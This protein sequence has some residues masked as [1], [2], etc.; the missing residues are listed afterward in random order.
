MNQDEKAIKKFGKIRNL[1]YDYVRAKAVLEQHSLIEY[2]SWDGKKVTLVLRTKDIPDLKPIMA[3]C[4]TVI[5]NEKLVT[6]TVI[7][8]K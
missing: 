4:S 3:V 6:K 2:E 5:W 1:V 8:A 7:N